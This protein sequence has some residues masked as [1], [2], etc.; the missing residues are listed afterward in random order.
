MG[1]GIHTH[2]HARA[3]THTHSIFV[4]GPVFRGPERSTLEVGLQLAGQ[5]C[6]PA[7][8]P[9]SKGGGWPSPPS[10]HV[11]LRPR[12]ADVTRG[13]Q[14]SRVCISSL[15]RENPPLSVNPRVCV[16]G[17]PG[18]PVASA[19]PFILQATELTKSAFF[20]CV[21]FL[22]R[23]F[24]EKREVTSPAATHALEQCSFSSLVQKQSEVVTGCEF[25]SAGTPQKP[26]EG[27]R[28]L[29]SLGFW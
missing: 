21:P 2:I 29:L 10:S 24:E 7:C 23:I 3:R 18:D 4:W 16:V 6:R 22:L 20:C 9:L 13:E 15:H 25:L 12:A 14:V 8:I 27:I 1:L 11:R 19:A 28:P 5:P 26:E 17:P